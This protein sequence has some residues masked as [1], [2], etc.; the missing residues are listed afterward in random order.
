[1]PFELLRGLRYERAP[2]PRPAHPLKVFAL[3]VTPRQLCPR[4]FF[5]CALASTVWGSAAWA[6]GLDANRV[7]VV[8]HEQTAELVATPPSEFVAFADANG[9]GL[10]N[11]AEVRARR[12]EILRALLASVSLTDGDG[13][14][15]ALDRSDVSVPRGD[16]DGARGSEFLR[17]TV[18]W[19]WPAAP[20][21]LR[22]RCGFVMQHPVTVFATRAES[23]S[24]PGMLTLVGDGEYGTLATAR[25]EATLLRQGPA[26][27]PAALPAAAA[28]APRSTL[29]AMF[30]A[31]TLALAALGGA[32][33]R[34]VRARR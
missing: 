27:Q 14:A 1:M 31:A 18:V 12:D 11:V 23:R 19:R 30:A 17:L 32:W 15:G 33:W 24:V 34:R 10:L 9:D 7:Q 5:A 25:S 21:S 16:D 2:T 13:R 29:P 28:P 26:P 8:V 6:H 22:V 20:A 3:P 4:H